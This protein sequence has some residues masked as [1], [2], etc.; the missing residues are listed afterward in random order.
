VRIDELYAASVAQIARGGAGGEAL[1]L[2]DPKQWAAAPAP[3]P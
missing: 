2:A 3:R 1:A